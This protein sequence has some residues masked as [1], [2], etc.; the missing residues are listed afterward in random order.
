M[1]NILDEIV[2]HKRVE[3]ASARL[4]RPESDLETLV[5][6]APAVRNFV[7]ALASADHIGLI[8]E[9]KR[10]SPSAGTIREDFQPVDVAQIY[11]RHGASCISVLTDERYF[12]GQLEDLT[13]VR[14]AVS[15]PVMRKDFILDRYQVLEARAAG[16]DCVLLIAECLET[17]QMTELYTTIRQLGMQALIE[18]FDPDNLQRVLDLKPDLLGINNRNL[19]TF[20]TA[21]DHTIQLQSQIPDSVLLVSESGIRTRQD[22]GRLRASGVRAILVGESLMRA[23]DIGAAVDALL[24]ARSNT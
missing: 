19:K 20:V 7:E 9:V 17:D 12:Q 8:A 15:I 4:R 18:I 16:A 3:I 6:Q 1:T 23:T 22:V 24:D 11:E 14:S 5:T 13:S 2:A 21:L 10:A